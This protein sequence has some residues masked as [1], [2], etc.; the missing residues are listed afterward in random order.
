MKYE[1]LVLE[2]WSLK[3]D[4]LIKISVY[5]EILNIVLILLTAF[6]SYKSYTA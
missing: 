2:V 3:F 5:L 4:R 6:T 1:T